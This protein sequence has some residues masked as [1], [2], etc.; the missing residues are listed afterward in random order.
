M[1]AAPPVVWWL[2][3]SD[4]RVKAALAVKCPA[5]TCLAAVGDECTGT[6]GLVHQCRVP[7]K[8]LGVAK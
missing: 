8:V 5:S 3:P 1:T 6:A 4:Y 2:D 7:H